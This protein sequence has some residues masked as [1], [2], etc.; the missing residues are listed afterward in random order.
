MRYFIETNSEYAMQIGAAIARWEK[1]DKI[2]IIEKGDPIEAIKID[3]IKIK[4]AFD[5]LE[6]LGINKEIMIAYI[7]T[8][9]IALATISSVLY[10]QEQFFEKLGVK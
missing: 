3:L 1:D 2:T 6:K 10:H 8:K 4:K 7:R 5:T 9:G